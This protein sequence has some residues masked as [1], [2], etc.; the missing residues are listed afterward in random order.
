M[1]TAKKLKFLANDPAEDVNMP[2]TKPV[3]KP[4]MTQD[5]ILKLIGKIHDLHDLCLM[6]VGIFCGPR[7][8]EV[9]GLQWRS[10]T[11]TTLVPHGTAFE[12]RFYPGR[13][14]NR[15]S[16]APIGVPEQVRPVIEAWKKLSPDPSPDALMFPTFGR[17][18]GKARRC[19]GGARTFS[20]GG[21]VRSRRSW[22]SRK[23]SSRF[24]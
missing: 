3:E 5:Q 13:L 15:S 12:G 1:Q 9:L 19:H 21:F 7:S 23:A 20:G 16:R 17:A 10:W 8:S 22:K 11:G 4:V 2:Q 18:S 14:K 6:Y 24:K